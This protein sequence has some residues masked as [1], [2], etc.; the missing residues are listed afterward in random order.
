MTDPEKAA[1]GYV[2]TF[3]GNECWWDKGRANNNLNNLDCKIIS[4]LGLGYQCSKKH[5]GF[6]QKWFSTDKLVLS[7]LKSCPVVPSGARSQTTFDEIKLR[8][9]ADTIIVFY[10][11]SGVRLGKQPVSWDWSESDY[12]KLTNNG[13]RLIKKE[14]SKINRTTSDMINQ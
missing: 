12:F 1:L 5:L 11:A 3:V 4:A 7:Q 9:K 2:A 14:Q 8:T 13:L 10:K 6:L